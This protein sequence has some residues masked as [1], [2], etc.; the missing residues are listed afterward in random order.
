M[1]NFLEDNGLCILSRVDNEYVIVRSKYGDHK[2]KYSHLRNH[3][4]P[5]IMSAIDKNSYIANQLK[6][7]FG[8]NFNFDKVDYVNAHSK[9]VIRCNKHGDF[10][11][12]PNCALKSKYLCPQCGNNASKEKQRSSI[13]YIIDKFKKVH[14]NKYSYPDITAY[15][16]QYT[17]IDIKCPVH[18]VFTQTVKDHL[19]GH[20][21]LECANII[22]SRARSLDPTGWTLSDWKASAF[23]SKEFDSFKVYILKC[24]NDKE[25]FI[26]I[27]RTYK[28]V[29]L[30]FR[31]KKYFPYKWDVVDIIEGDAEYIYNLEI[32]MKR[33]F[34]D[35]KYLPVEDFHGKYEC[36]KIDILDNVMN[37]ISFK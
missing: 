26:K 12:T 13:D 14:G 32:E 5:T 30:R 9:I 34:K 6:D 19:R 28:T 23:R 16:G 20:G 17:K 31:V 24:Y 37:Y 10:S 33:Y 29:G 1:D 11:I 4:K 7:I 25:S 18:G 2:V 8:D 3:T 36:F 15:K 35:F 21:C 27:G 22:R